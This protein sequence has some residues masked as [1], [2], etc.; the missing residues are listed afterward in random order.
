[1]SENQFEYKGKR[2]KAIDISRRWI[3]TCRGC[4]FVYPG[5]GCMKAPCVPIDRA[6]GSHV[7]WKKQP[8][9]MQRLLQLLFRESFL[10]SKK[11]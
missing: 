2:Y 4:D 6:D 9:K 11:G 8:S 10:L 1:M 7:I 5:D 3:R